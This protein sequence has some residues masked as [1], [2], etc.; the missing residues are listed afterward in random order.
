MDARFTTALWKEWK[1][2]SAENCPYRTEASYFLLYDFRILKY[3]ESQREKRACLF[4]L[5]LMCG[6]TVYKVKKN[7]LYKHEDILQVKQ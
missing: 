3:F 2:I 1:D 7:R 5:L 4:Q 6:H